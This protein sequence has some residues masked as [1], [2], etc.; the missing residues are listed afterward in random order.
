M[1]QLG[2]GL[3]N[4]DVLGR[5]RTEVDGIPV[6]ARGE[7]PDGTAF[8]G[9][10]ALKRLLLDRKQQF[11]R[12]LTS[13]MLGYALARELTNEDDCVV[14]DIVAELEENDYRSHTL[15]VEIVKSVLFRYKQ[16]QNRQAAVVHPTP[17]AANSD[18]AAQLSGQHQPL[19]ENR[20]DK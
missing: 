16:G 4:Y 14:E 15:I 7:L 3:E 20:R 18:A 6:D 12:H 1:D 10:A 13:K 2:F 9:P 5:W 17:A 8:D 11:I 19:E